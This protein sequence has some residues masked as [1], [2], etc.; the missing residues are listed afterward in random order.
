MFCLK[1]PSVVGPILDSMG[2]IVERA[3]ALL[4]QLAECSLAQPQVFGTSEANSIHAG[5]QVCQC[6]IESVSKL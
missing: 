4:D 1:Y 6:T 5:L 3:K 2:A